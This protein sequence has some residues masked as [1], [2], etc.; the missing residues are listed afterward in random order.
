MQ[1]ATTRERDVAQ[2]VPKGTSENGG[3]R[4][5]NRTAKIWN[6]DSHC[7]S[8]GAGCT[9]PEGERSAKQTCAASGQQSLTRIEQIGKLRDRRDSPRGRMSREDHES[10]R[11]AIPAL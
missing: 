4:S 6:R 10:R 5:H 9:N 1:S 3:T 7:N 11:Q 8:E 2:R